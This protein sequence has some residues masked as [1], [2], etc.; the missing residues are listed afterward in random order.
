MEDRKRE[1]DEQEKRLKENLSK[2]KHKIVVISGKGGVG[3][4]T[5]SVNLAYALALDGYSAGILDIDLHGPNVA[6]MLGIEGEQL[7]GSEFGLEPC[8]VVHNLKAVSMAMLLDSPDSPVIWRGPLKM[9]TIKQLL[10]DVNWGPLDY[11]VIDSPPGTGDEPLSICQLIPDLDGAVIVTTPQAVAVLDSRKTVVFARQLN[12]PVIGII[13]N[14]SGFLCPHCNE[15]IEL[16]GTGGG[17]RA[18]GELGVPFLGK[19]PIEPRI[20]ES[21]DT[22]QPYIYSHGQTETAG[23]MKEIVIKIREFGKA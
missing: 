19:V 1:Q 22:G 16:F 12:V 6:K 5:V 18:A 4:T 7:T 8:T 3:K 14:M 9:A 2:I 11:L 15:R 13:E 20:V 21:G 23:I 17:E 10:S